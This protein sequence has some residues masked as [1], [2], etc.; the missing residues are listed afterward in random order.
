MKILIVSPAYAPFSGVGTLRMLSLSEYLSN[1]CDEITVIRNDPEVWPKNQCY[2]KRPQN[3][4][5]VDVN[6]GN[7][8]YSNCGK[9]QAAI[10]DELTKKNYDIILY[11]VNPYYAEVI[12]PIIKR[13]YDLP[14]IIDIR[15]PWIFDE[16]TSRKFR[17]LKGIKRFFLSAKPFVYE[18]RCFRDASAIVCVTQEEAKWLGSIYPIFRKKF[19]VIY[20]GYDD[21][22]VALVNISERKNEN[23]LQVRVVCLGKLSDY[24]PRYAK[25]FFRAIIDL[26]GKGIDIKIVHIGETSSTDKEIMAEVNMPSQVYECIGNKGY[27]EGVD[28]ARNADMFVLMSEAKRGISTKALDYMALV[29]PTIAMVKRNGALYSLLNGKNNVAICRNKNDIESYIMDYISNR[30][31]RYGWQMDPSIQFYSRSVQNSLYYDLLKAKIGK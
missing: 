14:Y 31:D 10:I 2:A 5:T 26:I 29:R 4:S 11:S 9:Y 7:E 28:L 17:I 30:C 19:E 27:R 3:V 25:I 1:N 6:V 22:A 13:E 18:Y 21:Q 24:A 15:D 8:F 12:A 16:N 23:D 20:N